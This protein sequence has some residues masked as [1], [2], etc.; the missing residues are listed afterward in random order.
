MWGQKIKLDNNRAPVLIENLIPMQI[1]RAINEIC[2]Y[3]LVV[4]TDGSIDTLPRYAFI[5]A[6]HETISIMKKSEKPFVVLLNTLNPDSDHVKEAATDL[7]NKYKIRVIPCN[8]NQAKETDMNEI[9]SCLLNSY[10]IKEVNVNIPLDVLQLE[11]DHPLRIRFTNTI[12]SIVTDLYDTS[13]IEHVI[14]RFNEVNF[15]E[16]TEIDYYDKKLGVL[17]I[18][19]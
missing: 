9:F 4:S 12:K 14:N 13:A 17:E 6:E 5:D 1:E 19:L 18:S 8:L 2:E 16:R 11:E 15:I 10:P 3:G 7:I